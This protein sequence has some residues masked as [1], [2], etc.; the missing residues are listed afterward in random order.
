MSN[1]THDTLIELCKKDTICNAVYNQCFDKNDDASCEQLKNIR[2]D[3]FYHL[4]NIREKYR[5]RI[6]TNLH[7]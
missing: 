1:I 3:G 7:I 5:S 6:L 4:L 2:M